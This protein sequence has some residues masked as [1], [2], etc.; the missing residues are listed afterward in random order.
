[1]Y[2]I[3]DINQPHKFT[4]KKRIYCEDVESWLLSI[5]I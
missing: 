1:M 3:V 4:I 2:A 5:N